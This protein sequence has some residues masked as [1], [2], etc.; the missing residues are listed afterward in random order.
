MYQTLMLASLDLVVGRITTSPTC[1]ILIP[2]AQ[3]FATFYGKEE[4]KLQ[5]E[6]RWL[7]S[8]L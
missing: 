6:L 5:V 4:L 1:L 3:A 2:E 8:S 7:V